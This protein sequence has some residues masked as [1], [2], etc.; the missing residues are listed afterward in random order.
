M[1]G[2]LSQPAWESLGSWLAAKPPTIAQ[3]EERETV[4]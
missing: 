3:L 4:V 2:L 1:A